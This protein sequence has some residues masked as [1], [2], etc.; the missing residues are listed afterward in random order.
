MYIFVCAH[1]HLCRGLYLEISSRELTFSS[2]YR[3]EQ[4]TTSER[5]SFHACVGV[6]GWPLEGTFTLNRTNIT[7]L[8]SEAVTC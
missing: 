5:T 3:D 4:E 1:G 2:A 6:R 8:R 7:V